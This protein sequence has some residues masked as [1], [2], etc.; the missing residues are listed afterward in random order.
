MTFDIAG[1]LQHFHLVGYSECKL[2]LYHFDVVE[3]YQIT[4]LQQWF[5]HVSELVVELGQVLCA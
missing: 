3:H 1:S 2:Q 4:G 5:L